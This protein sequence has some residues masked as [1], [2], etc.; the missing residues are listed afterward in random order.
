LEENIEEDK[1]VRKMDRGQLSK[2]KKTPKI[3]LNHLMDNEEGQDGEA[4]KTWVKWT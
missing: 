2:Q 3:S 1:A 4:L